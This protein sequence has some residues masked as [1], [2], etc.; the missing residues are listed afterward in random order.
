MVGREEER[1]GEIGKIC[2]LINLTFADV[3]NERIPGER[4]CQS[5]GA[6]CFIV[7]KRN[8]DRLCAVC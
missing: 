4:I 1:G 6:I 2:L 8:R 5:E 3:D 7:K